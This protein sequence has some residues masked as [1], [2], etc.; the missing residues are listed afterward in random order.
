MKSLS[1]SA[2]VKF[3][4]LF[5]YFCY[6]VSLNISAAETKSP[7]FIEGVEKV[8][9]EGII[10]L[11]EQI[12]ELIIIDSRIQGDRHKGYLESSVSLPDAE[13]NCQSLSK[14]IPR[15]DSAALFYCNGIKCGRSVVAIDIAKKCGYTKLYWFRGGFDAWMKKGFPFIKR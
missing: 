7:D 15:Y 5:V 1:A 9:A 4:K 12:D 13:T 10:N 6:F 8:S 14:V 11:I 3:I 2:S